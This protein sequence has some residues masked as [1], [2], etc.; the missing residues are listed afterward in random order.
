MNESDTGEG[1]DLFLREE[2]KVVGVISR[3][4]RQRHVP[5][6]KLAKPDPVP[7][8]SKDA[9]KR[10]ARRVVDTT[11]KVSEEEADALALEL[12]SQAKAKMDR[13]APKPRRSGLLWFLKK[14]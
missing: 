13:L 4:R 8:T 5:E 14:K 7:V 12:I 3:R 2:G 10:I 6:E 11:V 9:A 1:D